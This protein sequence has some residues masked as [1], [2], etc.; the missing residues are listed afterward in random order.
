MGLLPNFFHSKEDLNIYWPHDEYVFIKLSKEKKINA[1][2]DEASKLIEKMLIDEDEQTI[3]I[4]KESIMMNRY[5]IKQ[6]FI[7]ENYTIKLNYNIYDF[8][9]SYLQGNDCMIQNDQYTYNI[10]R[11]SE[12]WMD[13]NRWKQEVVWYGHKKGSYLYPII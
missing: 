11:M 4:L 1:F 2:Y 3:K 7:N 10:D 6:P 9:K 8:Y 13:W 5:L 12:V